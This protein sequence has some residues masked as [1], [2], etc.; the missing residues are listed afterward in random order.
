[1]VLI[2]IIFTACSN[3]VQGKYT[4]FNNELGKIDL[5]ITDKNVSINF[6][7]IK[8]VNEN[9]ENDMSDSGVAKYKNM[10]GT[11]DE[12]SKEIKLTT[13]SGEKVNAT[14]KV[15]DDVIILTIQG[16]LFESKFFKKD[17]EEYKKHAKNFNE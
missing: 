9:S 1:M 7:T 10:K 17:S 11:I 16:L 5:N 6:V 14:Y 2:L 8:D 15:Q 4:S 3:G 13:D 12:E